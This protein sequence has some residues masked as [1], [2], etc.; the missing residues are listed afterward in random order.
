ML[1]LS[2]KLNEGLSIGDD[3]TIK[4]V[5][6][7]KGSVKIGIDAPRSKTILRTELIEAVTDANKA[8]T[9]KIDDDIFNQLHKKLD[10]K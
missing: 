7:E 6:I 2:R 9:A 4:V 8:A 10:K 1:V 5:S 3:I